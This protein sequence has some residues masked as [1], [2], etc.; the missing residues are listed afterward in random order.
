MAAGLP[1]EMHDWYCATAPLQ[2]RCHAP[3]CRPPTGLLV[4]GRPSPAQP[5]TMEAITDRLPIMEAVIKEAMRLMPAIGW[6]TAREADEDMQLGT[7]QLEKGTM[8][9]GVAQP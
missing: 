9:G 4:D 6:G 1:S 7:I 5:L 2:A 8:V 3:R